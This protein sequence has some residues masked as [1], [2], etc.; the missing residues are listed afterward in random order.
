VQARELAG[1]GEHH[2]QAHGGKGHRVVKASRGARPV[3]GQPDHG[4]IRTFGD[5]R[6]EA[7]IGGRTIRDQVLLGGDPRDPVGTR[8]EVGSTS[9]IFAAPSGIPAGK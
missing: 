5:R 4:R 3:V 7:G 1:D 8:T 9:I 2:G 6:Q